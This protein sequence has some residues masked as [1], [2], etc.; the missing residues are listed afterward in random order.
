MINILLAVFLGS[1]IFFV[2]TATVLLI[3]AIKNEIRG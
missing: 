1:A 2:I 3:M